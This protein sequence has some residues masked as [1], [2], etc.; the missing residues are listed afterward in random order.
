MCYYKFSL[1]DMMKENETWWI[2]SELHEYT[3]G[4]KCF[5]TTELFYFSTLINIIT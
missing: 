2:V 4:A 3:V 1:F 5:I